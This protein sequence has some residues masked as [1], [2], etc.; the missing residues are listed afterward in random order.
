MKIIETKIE[1]Q[2]YLK[3]NSNSKIGFI[4]TMGALHQ[5]HLELV[6]RSKEENDV[7]V[8]SIF[9]NPTQFNNSEDLLKYP[10]TLEEDCNKLK[11][12]GCDAVFAPSFEEMYVSMPTIKFDFGHL[13]HI[14]EGKFRPGHFNGVG[15]VVSKLFNIVKPT[16][17]YFGQKDI[18]QVAVI[19]S[20]VKDLSFDLKIIVCD[21][22]R[23]KNGLAMSS[24]NRRLSEN[25]KEI[26]PKIYESLLLAKKLLLMGVNAE[27][28]KLEI[29]NFYKNFQQFELEYF[30]ITDYSSLENIAF[31]KAEGQTAVIIATY[32]D[33]VRL[34]DNL[35]F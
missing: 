32:L 9:V 29:R 2:A 14:M 13:E 7:S 25:A 5:G 18:Q 33:G 15:I 28:T 8:C 35:I 34:I 21:T 27:N 6:K 23:E 12:I 20:L 19:K 1:I 3:S 22:I 30:E 31:H 4:P 16:Q 10:R 17:A 11:E 26:A 24:R